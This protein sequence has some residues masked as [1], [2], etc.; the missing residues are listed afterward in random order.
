[1]KIIKIE[2]KI[3]KLICTTWQSI[4]QQPENFFKDI[5]VVIGD[6]A[7]KF[8]AKSLISIMEKLKTTEYRY[9]TTGTL[10]GS[11]T[12]KLVLEGLFGKVEK[13]ITTHEMIEQK[14]AADFKIKNIVLSYPDD[15]RKM[16]SKLKYED[17]RN[18]LFDCDKRNQFIANLALS[19]EGNTIVLFRYIEKHGDKLYNLIKSANPDCPVYYIHGKVDGNT[20]EEIR[21]K[22]NSHKKSITIASEGTMS[23]GTNIPEL[24]NAIFASPSKARVNTLQS[25]GRLLR[26]STKNMVSTLYDISD[27]LTWREKKNTTLTH[28][29]ERIK[30]YNEEKFVYKNYK[31]QL[32][33]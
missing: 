1:M 12:N 13:I 21:L 17:E 9:G 14:Y 18:F 6:E 11:Q 25:I 2:H 26:L 19:L 33:I 28:F 32:R 22:I 3:P 10:D 29:M 20:R 8:K 23:T 16:V 15:V 27:D 31:V 7:H 30:I 5:E 24:H 4:Y